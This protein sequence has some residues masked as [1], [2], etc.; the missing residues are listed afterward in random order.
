[1]KQLSKNRLV[2]KYGAIGALLMLAPAVL[3]VEIL[4]PM[5]SVQ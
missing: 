3:V 4:M 2:M 1:M 5:L